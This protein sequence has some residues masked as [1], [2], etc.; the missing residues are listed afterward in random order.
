M[1][2]DARDLLRRLTFRGPALCDPHAEDMLVIAFERDG[3]IA[4]AAG[5]DAPV[6]LAE[7]LRE[8]VEALFLYDGIR[9]EAAGIRGAASHL[10]D[11]PLRRVEDVFDDV[12]EAVQCPCCGSPE[13]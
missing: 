12:R 8:I 11:E 5:T 6:R 2:D 1:T 10:T 3:R 4:I 9:E 7:R 13:A